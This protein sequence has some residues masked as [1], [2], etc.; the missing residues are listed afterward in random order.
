[1]RK[2]AILI[3]AIVVMAVAFEMPSSVTGFFVSLST[4][5]IAIFKQILKQ[6]L[7]AIANML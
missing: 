1:M 5:I 3:L 6:V 4:S 7:L 2:V